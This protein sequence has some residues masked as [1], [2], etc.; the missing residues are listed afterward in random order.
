MRELEADL[1]IQTPTVSKILMQDLGM[2]HVVAK[3]VPWL[4]LP[5]QKEHFAAL[6]NDLV[7][8]SDNEPAFL[9]K[10]ITDDEL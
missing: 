10:V 6:A 1:R 2:K 8:S 4:L 3:V 5:G 9:K 7:Q